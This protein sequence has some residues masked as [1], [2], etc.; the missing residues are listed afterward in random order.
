MTRTLVLCAAAVLLLSLPARAGDS[1]EAAMKL[2]EA[3]EYSKAAE[4][5]E[6]VGADDP[7]YAR[8]RYLAGES[9]LALGEPDLAEAHF[10]AALE[11]KPDAIPAQTGLGRALLARGK[12]D[13]ALPVLEKAVKAD[14]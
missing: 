7:L 6:K 12:A 14:G 4:A 2:F 1:V 10:R 3:G 11:K 5:A 8:A 13:E 9:R